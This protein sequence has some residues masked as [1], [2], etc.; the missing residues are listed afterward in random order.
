MLYDPRSAM[1]DPDAI[2]QIL[3]TSRTIA[4][5]GLT[6]STWRPAYSVSKYLQK[7]GYR[8]VPVGP[9][10]EVLGEQ[11]YPDLRSVPFPID[12]VDIFRRSDRV[13]PHVE[14]AIAV[15]ARCVWLQMGIRDPE[16]EAQAEA[17]GL[18]V[19]A[20]LCTMVEH[21]RLT[22]YAQT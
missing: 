11:G 3:N 16:A 9:S 20:D 17:A 13:R 14:E 10:P 6:A 8:V 1:N 18:V 19:V 12:V 5:V 21:I 7:V 15:G 22:R 2:A 4:V